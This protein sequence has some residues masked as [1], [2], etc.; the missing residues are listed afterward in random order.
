MS[1]LPAR[2]DVVRPAV[3]TQVRRW[4]RERGLTLAQVAE[5]SDLNIGY[6]SQIENDKATPSLDCLATLGAA[7]GVPTAWFLLDSTSPPRVVRAGERRSWS[8]P[9]GLGISEV[10]GGIPRDLRIVE[11]TSGVGWRTGLHA[12]PGDEHHVILSGHWRFSQGDHVLDAGPG[13][14]VLWDGTIPHDVENIGPEP[15]SILLISPRTSTPTETSRPEAAGSA[16]TPTPT[17]SR[18]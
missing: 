13:D 5:R 14:Y 9:G 18:S 10:D 7:L 11:A 8:A 1:E 15:G 17:R 2:A 6:L 12:H 4:R 3:G 16:T